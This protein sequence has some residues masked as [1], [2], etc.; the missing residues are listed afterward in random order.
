MLTIVGDNARSL[1]LAVVANKHGIP[2]TIVGS[3]KVGESLPEELLRQSINWD[4]VS[5]LERPSYDQWRMDYFLKNI[6]NYN[7]QGDIEAIP[8]ISKET[9]D[10]YIANCRQ[11]LTQLGVK[12]ISKPVKFLSRNYVRFNDESVYR[13]KHLCIALEPKAVNQPLYIE[14]KDYNKIVPMLWTHI[15][16]CKVL[17]IPNGNE[18]YSMR[19]SIYLKDMGHDVTYL[20]D[21]YEVIKGTDYEVPSFKEWGY[22]TALGHFYREFL[23]D[24]QSRVSYL[25]G[26]EAFCSVRP[27]VINEFRKSGCKL[28][29]YNSVNSL[30]SLKRDISIEQFDYFID[31]RTFKTDV[32]KLVPNDCIIPSRENNLYPIVTEGMRSPNG[33]YFTGALAEYFDGPRQNYM[34]SAGKTSLEI[35]R[36]IISRNNA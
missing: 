4:L 32:S 29:K 33:V 10:S 9:W 16:P 31:L 6:R 13:Y 26:V 28:L 3:Y 15:S 27:N 36:N 23:N 20:L 18:D 14:H 21:T 35:V 5:N 24:K 1:S 19:A 12:F 25:R 2:V 8:Y 34:L 7:S 17:V 30:N 11:Q 22:K